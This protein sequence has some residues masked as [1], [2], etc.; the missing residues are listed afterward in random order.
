MAAAALEAGADIV[1]DITW[2]LDPK[3]AAVVA[4]HGERRSH[5]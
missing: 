2:F 4:E 5:V 1:N 3:M